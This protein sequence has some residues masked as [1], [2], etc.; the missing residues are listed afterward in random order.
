LDTGAVQGGAKHP[1]QPIMKTN[2]YLGGLKHSFYTLLG[3]IIQFD[4]HMFQMGW[5]N[6]QVD[7]IICGKRVKNLANEG[8][9]SGIMTGYTV[10]QFVKSSAPEKDAGSLHF[11]VYGGLPYV[12]F[13]GFVFKQF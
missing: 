10:L 7:M 12:P 5:F 8:I 1:Y 11:S 6:H 4:E 9:I 2:G 13:Y 3:E